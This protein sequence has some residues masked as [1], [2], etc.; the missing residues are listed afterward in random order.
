MKT[1]KVTIKRNESLKG[2]SK[3][4]DYS[5]DEISDKMIEA[6]INL[7]YLL[8]IPEECGVSLEETLSDSDTT[9][10]KFAAYVFHK[11]TNTLI[12]ILK[13][14]YIWGAADDCEECGCLQILDEENEYKECENPAC[15]C[16]KKVCYKPDPDL[17]REERVS[18]LLENINQN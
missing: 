5:E 2:I 11:K 7:K 12:N 3:M 17:Y 14:I 6:L 15:N 13:G 4:S 16:S 18:L 9:L 10:E 1:I 8:D